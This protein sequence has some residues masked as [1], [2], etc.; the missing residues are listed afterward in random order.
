MLL[1][2]LEEQFDL[3]SL[4]VEVCDLQCGE[5]EIVGEEDVGVLCLCVVE[6]HTS[7]EI[8]IVRFRFY[9]RETDRLIAAQSRRSIDN[10]G[11]ETLPLGVAFR[12][13]DEE[14]APLVDVMES[15]KIDVPTI[16]DVTGTV[17]DRKNIEHIHVM[18]RSVRD[19]DKR[20]QIAS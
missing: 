14:G 10:M 5:N 19:V 15:L 12:S 11:V 6:L 2:P 20:G 16:H 9:T 4:L 8:G 17:F 1:D 18:Y 3:P 7:Q 13:R